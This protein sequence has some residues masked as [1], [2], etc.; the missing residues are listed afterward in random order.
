MSKYP[1]YQFR[2]PKK[3]KKVFP[4]TT[5]EQ[6]FHH[7]ERIMISFTHTKLIFLI[8][9]TSLLG[10]LPWKLELIFYYRRFIEKWRRFFPVSLG[11]AL[12]GETT[13]TRQIMENL[14]LGIEYLIGHK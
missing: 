10:Q 12:Y 14:V 5:Q 4:T 13:S 3:S 9:S 11:E 8:N 2:V 6:N 7:Q 1:F